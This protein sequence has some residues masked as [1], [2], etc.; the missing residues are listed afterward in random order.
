MKKINM[1]SY[2]NSWM[3]NFAVWQTELHLTSLKNVEGYD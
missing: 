1:K 2:E 3:V